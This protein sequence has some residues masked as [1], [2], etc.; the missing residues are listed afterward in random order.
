MKCTKCNCSVEEKMLHRTGPMGQEPNW[1]CMPCIQ[2]YEPELAANIAEKMSD[3]E[4]DLEA[5]MYPKS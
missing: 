1:M 4:H 3:V 2:S 5:L